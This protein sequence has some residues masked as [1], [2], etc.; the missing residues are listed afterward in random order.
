MAWRTHSKVKE[1]RQEGIDGDLLLQMIGFF[2]TRTKRH[3]D[4]M[5]KIPF[6]L[7]LRGVS[8]SEMDDTK[9]GTH[10]NL[11]TILQWWA[12]L[13]YTQKSGQQCSLITLFHANEDRTASQSSLNCH[14]LRFYPTYLPWYHR[15]LITLSPFVRYNFLKNLRLS[16]PWQ[17]PLCIQ[18][19]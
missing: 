9:M 4:T 16:S 5:P 3:S 10:F 13:L 15:D 18:Y 19:Q 1:Q 6:L 11:P 12:L 14:K 17:E 8:N 2:N 7:K